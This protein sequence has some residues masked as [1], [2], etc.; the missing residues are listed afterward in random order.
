MR[1]RSIVVVPLLAAVTG[2]LFVV[3]PA[4]SALGYPPTACPTLA[5]STTHPLAGQPITVTGSGFAPHATIRLELRPP[6]GRQVGTVHSDTQGNFA[7]TITLP[8]GP[9]RHDLVAVGGSQ[10]GTSCPVDPSQVLQA[11]VDPSQLQQ[12]QA[13]ASPSGARQHGGT[14]FTGLDIAGLVLAALALLGGGVLLSRTGRRRRVT[15]S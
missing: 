14:A 10:A 5:V 9:G 4:G 12:V 1:L 6:T 2:L 11:Q 15:A 13:N 8:S 3:G 7:T